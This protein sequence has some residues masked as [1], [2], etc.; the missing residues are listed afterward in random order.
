MLLLIDFINP[1]EFEG[2]D[3]LAGPAVV[4][5]RAVGRLRAR[6]SAAGMQTIYANDNYGRWHSDFHSVWQRCD[7]AGGPA[8]E[9]ARALRPRAHDL[10]L[11]KPRH[12]A[13]YC[14]PLEMLLRQL[15]CERLVITGLA[16]DSC[17]LF[18]AMDAYLRGFEL[19]I[20]ADCVAAEADEAHVNALEHMGRVLKA[21]TVRAFD[22]TAGS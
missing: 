12:S 11:L 21:H 16:A 22:K 2:A 4:A 13:F 6:M 19:W 10:R 8:R 15:K 20:P 3:A 14:T 5:A 1:L 17:V 9:M 7:R 18:T